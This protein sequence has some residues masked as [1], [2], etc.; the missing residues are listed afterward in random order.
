MLYLHLQV[1]DRK[2]LCG[3]SWGV[4]VFDEEHAL[5]T[6]PNPNPNPVPDPNPD[7]NPKPNPSPNPNQVQLA[8]A[9][10]CESVALLYG[11]PSSSKA[12]A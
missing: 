6:N 2:F 7:P 5:K 8:A 1:A 10:G 12:L 11:A 4:V 3:H 9:D